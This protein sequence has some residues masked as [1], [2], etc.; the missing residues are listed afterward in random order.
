M[1]IT[2]GLPNFCRYSTA[3]NN[4]IG[5]TTDPRFSR[6][7]PYPSDVAKMVEAPI[8]HCNGDDPAV[9]L[10]RGRMLADP[11]VHLRLGE[12]RLVALVMAEAAVAP[13]DPG[14]RAGGR[15]RLQAQQGRLARRPLV[16]LQGCA[17]GRVIRVAMSRSVSSGTPVRPRRGS[18]TSSRPAPHDPAL[19]RQPRQGG[20][21]RR[22]HRL[23]HRR[24]AR[25]R[26]AADRRLSK[27]RWIVRCR[28]KPGGGVVIRVAMS[29]SVSSGT[30]VRPRRGSSTSPPR[31]SPSAR[32]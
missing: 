31:R 23:G 18:S 2:T 14:E 29:R 3:I 28:W 26:L 24:G 8:F 7:S 11:L 12:G 30:P 10:Q 27:K 15:G 21:D 5:F 19:L 22:R 16:R 6:S 32:C 1:S 9:G 20:R 25:L 4:Q 13:R 17:R